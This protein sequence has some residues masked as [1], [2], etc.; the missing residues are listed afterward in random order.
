MS[1]TTQPPQQI[2]VEPY[3]A[4]FPE[5]HWDRWTG[6]LDSSVSIYGWLPRPDGRADFVLVLID[7]EGPFRYHTSSAAMSEEIGR[8][9]GFS[10][11]Q[12]N[13]CKRVAD[14]WPSVKERQKR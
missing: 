6:D 8:R 11:G 1:S 14:T 13:Q 10:P 12:H 3:L 7:Q 2:S 9:L 4:L 5:V